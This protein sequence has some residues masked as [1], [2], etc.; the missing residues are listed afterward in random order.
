M[1]VPFVLAVV[2]RKKLR[3]HLKGRGQQVASRRSESYL[4]YFE[5]I[6]RLQTFLLNEADRHS[7]PIIPNVDEDETVQEVMNTISAVLESRYDGDPKK[8]FK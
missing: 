1:I 5:S 7:V 2:K 8:A 4:K 6:W 3:K